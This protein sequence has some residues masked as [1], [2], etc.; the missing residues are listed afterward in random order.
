MAILVDESTRLVVQGIT[1]REGSFHAAQMLAYGTKVVAGVSPGKG[2]LKVLDS[3][4]VYDTVRQAVNETGANTSIIFVPAPYALD[5]VLESIEAGIPLTVII[6]EHVPPADTWKAVSYAARKG[7][8]IIGPNCPGLISPGKA[9]VGIMPASVFKPGEIGVVSRSG[10]LTYEVSHQLT[11]SGFGQSSVIGIGGDPIVGTG[12]KEVL[13]MFEKDEAT[14]AVVIIGEIGGDAEEKA[15]AY[16]AEH[17]SKPIVAYIAGRTAPPGKRMG[18][19]GAIVS[20]TEGTVDA[21]TRAFS[22]A[23]VAVAKTPSE[24]PLLIARIT[25]R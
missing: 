25:R 22:E 11:R 17:V 18:H 2:G 7:V 20:G 6:T 15:A 14:K 12:F 10:T 4:P 1:G 21:K 24:I 5:A 16:I 19:A 9:K 23:G 3:V 8:R 13:E